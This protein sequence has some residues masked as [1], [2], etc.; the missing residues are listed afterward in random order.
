MW[1]FYED[2]LFYIPF[3]ICL[4]IRIEKKL[5]AISRQEVI[6][7]EIC[8]LMESTIKPTLTFVMIVKVSQCDWQASVGGVSL[9]MWT[10]QHPTYLTQSPG[11]F[12]TFYQS[13]SSIQHVNKTLQGHE[14]ITLTTI[15]PTICITM[16][17]IIIMI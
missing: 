3:K 5:Y 15:T 13:P 14:S 7:Q 12:N 6:N 1:I 8:L 9:S 16:M 17:T 11:S 4:L 2:S 10:L